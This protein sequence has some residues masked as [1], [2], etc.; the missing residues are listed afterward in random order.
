V[1]DSALIFFKL[2]AKLRLSINDS[3]DAARSIYS[4]GITFY[5]MTNYDSALVYLFQSLKLK[6]ELRMDA[7]SINNHTVI[8]L[9]Y[10]Q[11]WDSEK[12]LEHQLTALKLSRENN[13]KNLVNVLNNIG[14]V[15]M[16]KKEFEKAIEY[17]NQVIEKTKAEGK[18]N[19]TLAGAL[20]NIG[21]CYTSLG[22]YNKAINFHLEGLEIRKK[23][24]DIWGVANSCK[25]TGKSY[26]EAGNAK[27]SIKY[28]EEG[29]VIAEEIGSV[30]IISGIY[31]YLAM[32]YEL[33]NNFP[34]AYSNHKQYLVYYDS[35]NEIKNG[36]LMAETQ[37]KYE[38]EQKEQQI[39]I[40]GKENEIKEL[41]LGQSRNL[42]LGLIGMAVLILIIGGLM[43]RYN[44]TIAKHKNALLEQKLLRSQM[45]P[46]FIFNSLIAIQSFI[47]ENNA[48]TAGNYLSKFADLMRLILENSRQEYVKFEKEKKTL[49]LYLELQALRFDQ[50]FNYSI[51]VDP[52]IEMKGL[53]IPPM[54]AQPFLEN[55]IEHGIGDE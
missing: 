46:H 55:A 11:T 25:N 50:K 38:T 2:A 9:I 10:Y 23:I 24:D 1:Y 27:M 33:D 52:S 51:E 42:N 54:L 12:S 28:L 53:K 21:L 6:E 19:G 14:I 8:G 47:Y 29:L 35:L 17:Y 49:E 31:R 45:N 13:N 22:N 16:D 34:S 18:T 41:K 5:Y 36:E 37:T 32:A 15:Y 43:I 39:Q 48:L 7:S 20:D 26:L 40:L 4:I 30:N 44:K 3:T